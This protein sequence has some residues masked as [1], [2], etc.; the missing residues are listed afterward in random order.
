VS[1]VVI[2]GLDVIPIAASALQRSKRG[3]RLFEEGLL[4]RR[5]LATEDLVAMREASK[6]PDHI[7]MLDGK[8]KKTRK[9]LPVNRRDRHQELTVEPYTSVLIDQVFGV[10]EWEIEKQPFDGPQQEISPGIQTLSSDYSS[11]CILGEGSRG[12]AVDGTR[13]LIEQQN[14][15]KTPPR[16]AGPMVQHVRRRRRG[17]GTEICL[18]HL[19]NLCPVAPPELRLGLGNRRIV[20]IISKPEMQKFVFH[21]FQCNASSYVNSCRQMRISDF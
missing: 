3:T 6:L 2:L 4:F 19:I 10:L 15:R 17:R 7:P 16:R 9:G 8:I 13:Q 20:L 18:Q 5:G 21:V 11:S 14:Q 1:L 12:G